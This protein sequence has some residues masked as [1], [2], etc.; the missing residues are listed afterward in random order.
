MGGI[1]DFTDLESARQRLREIAPTGSI[2]VVRLEAALN[3]V[4]A[5][6]VAT[7]LDDPP[8]DRAMMDGY[9]VR[10]EDLPDPPGSP[11]LPNL[12]VLLNLPDFPGSPDS[13]EAS[14]LAVTLQVVGD[15]AAG[16]A[17][18]P[19]VGAGKAVRISTGAPIPPGA[20]AVI[21]V[22]HTSPEG[23]GC[24]VIKV[25]PR[26]GQN[27]SQRGSNTTVGATVLTAPRT[28]RA[29]D[30]AVA[31]AAGRAEMQ[32]YR[33][34]AVG[35]ITTGAELV[36][37]GASPVGGQIRNSNGPL[38]CSL[39]QSLLGS[40]V[41]F[42]S[43]G[44]EPGPLKAAIESALDRCDLLCVTG[45]VSMGEHDHVPAVLER[46]GVETHVRKVRIK[47]GKPIQI[48]VSSTGKVVFALP[49]NPVSAMIG[50]HLFVKPAVMLFQ[51]LDTIGA[52]LPTGILT[53]PLKATA[54]RMVFTPGGAEVRVDGG[55]QLT[56]NAWRGSGDAFGCAGA[57]AF[58]VQSA[59]APPSDIGARLAFL[60]M[61]R[62]LD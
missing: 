18:L 28:L 21:Q 55:I 2:E 9:A 36:A 14:D 15:V 31:A 43:V 61:D 22:E 46:L 49:G 26:A 56:P 38:L 13:R 10:V 59:Q 48:G 58:I 41:G 60:P 12:P 30:I 7:D 32:V 51:G 1:L 39:I 37:P 8:F 57:N 25:A 52:P 33:R 27:I 34:P 24:V 16:A 47:P 35:V 62:F 29:A 40:T 45:G 19:K 20:N 23:D 11:D 42:E 3:R 54:D 6:P 53:A 44:D 17:T 50:F 5:A 4:L